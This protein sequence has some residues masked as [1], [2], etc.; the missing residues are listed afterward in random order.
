M[1]NN[2]SNSFITCNINNLATSLKLELDKISQIPVIIDINQITKTI[3]IPISQHIDIYTSASNEFINKSSNNHSNN[4]IYIYIF[5]NKN[6]ESSTTRTITDTKIITINL[7][8]DDTYTIISTTKN[9]C[10]ISK[11]IKKNKFK[12]ITKLD[13][14]RTLY[15]FANK[16]FFIIDS[17]GFLYYF[18]DSI[19]TTQSNVS[20]IDNLKKI[21]CNLDESAYTLLDIN[22]FNKSETTQST[23]TYLLSWL[24]PL[25]YYPI[26][27]SSSIDTTTSTTK[28]NINTDNINTVENGFYLDTL[29]EN[30]IKIYNGYMKRLKVKK[31]EIPIHITEMYIND[32]DELILIGDIYNLSSKANNASLKIKFNK[33]LVS[34]IIL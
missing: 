8:I 11:I 23:I 12:L 19:E 18:P 20:N 32:I 22:D 28:H 6:N 10:N 24:N 9:Q 17:S 34:M 1:C 33:Y 13:H 21:E 14:T 4:H 5:S 25:S 2:T 31:L 3:S 15:N 30:I 27:S 7:N 16:Y 29:N 26:T